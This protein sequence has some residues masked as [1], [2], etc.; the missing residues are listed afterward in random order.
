MRESEQPHRAERRDEGSA[1]AVPQAANREQENEASGQDSERHV[2]DVPDHEPETQRAEK[3][4]VRR[5]AGGT[6]GAARDRE[7]RPRHLPQRA[8]AMIAARWVMATTRRVDG[9]GG[10]VTESPTEELVVRDGSLV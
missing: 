9:H 2:H 7:E 8:R 4:G 6:H 10:G 5:K 3:Q 1:V